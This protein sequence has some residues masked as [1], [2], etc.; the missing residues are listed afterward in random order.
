M[1]Q[2]TSIIFTLLL[3]TSFLTACSDHP[4]QQ[5]IVAKYTDSASKFISIRG[6][7]I[8]YKDEGEGEIIVLI[9]GTASSLHTWDLWQQLLSK[10]FRVIRMDLPGFGLTGPDKMDRY[11][12]TDDIDFLKTLLAKLN[13]EQ[14]HFVGNS[15]GGRIAWQYTIEYPEAVKTLTLM[16]ALGYPQESWPPAIQLAMSPG[17]ETIMPLVSSR[18]IFSQSLNDIYFNREL[19]TEQTIDRYFELSLVAGNAEAFPKR[20]K[21]K[22]DDQWQKIDQVSVPTLILWGKEDQYFSAANAM[23]FATD[24][25]DAKVKLYENVGHLPMEEIPKQSSSDFIKFIQAQSKVVGTSEY[26]RFGE[27]Y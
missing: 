1:K 18:F 5:Q 3:M 22:L 20:V 12:V 6:N 15:L 11:E 27:V 14:A 19:I 17:M 13:I 21:A 16:N 7:Q 9:H 25:P 24:I 10:Q 4:S 2:V 26:T 8:H 23:R